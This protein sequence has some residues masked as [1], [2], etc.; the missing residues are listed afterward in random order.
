[1]FWLPIAISY[2]QYRNLTTAEGLQILSIY[3]LMIVVLEYPTGVIGDQY[4]HKFSVLSGLLSTALGFFLLSMDGS[5]LF[6]L[7]S[8]SFVALGLSLISGSDTALLHSVSMDF[9]KDY[10]K[11]NYQALL[12]TI[13]STAV[14]SVLASIYMPLPYLITGIMFVIS[15][16]I[17]YSVNVSKEISNS[18]NIFHKGVEGLLYLKESTVV[19]SL[20]GV[21]V[22]VGTFTISL[23]WFYNPLFET[24]NIPLQYWGG[25]ISIA[26][27]LIA[28]GTKLYE[29]NSE[30]IHIK[31]V[32]SLFCLSIVFIGLTQSI[33]LS[34]LGLFSVNTIRGYLQ[35]QIDVYLNEN[36]SSSVRASVLSLKSLLIRL[37]SS[38]YIF[39]SSSVITNSRYILFF[40]VTAGVILIIGT[41]SLWNKQ[42][43]T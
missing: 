31:S 25:L 7:F 9:K 1:M 43:K 2:F 14:G 24:M 22:L 12:W 42:F 39:I 3:S 40:S 38:G 29:R 30:R 21:G 11:F 10:A 36:L 13:F 35:T 5:Y 18:A 16:L 37:F 20:I 32:F 28:I 26:M 15:F 6:F 33:L 34:L 4:S 17:L 27:F 8:S 19:Q 23:K 41:I